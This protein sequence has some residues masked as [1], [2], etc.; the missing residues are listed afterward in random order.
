MVLRKSFSTLL[1]VTLLL[2]SIIVIKQ[3]FELKIDCTNYRL[4]NRKELTHCHY[5]FMIPT[6]I[7]RDAPDRK[8][9]GYRISDLC[10][11]LSDIR[12]PVG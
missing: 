9:I 1:S 3:M 5:M 2:S 6:V 10:H 11:I 12:Y 7:I 4:T 8:I